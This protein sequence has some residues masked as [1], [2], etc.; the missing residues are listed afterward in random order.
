[1]G[2]PRTEFVLFTVNKLLQN[3]APH[4][5]LRL[6]LGDQLNIRHSWFESVDPG[7]LYVIAEV[8]QETDY[9]T[10]HV[11]KVCAFFL[12]MEAFAAALASRGHAVCYLTLDDTDGESLPD[13]LATIVHQTDASQLEYQRP[14]EY[15]LA[16]QLE[17]MRIESV[18][19]S[20]V[21]TQ[22]FLLPFEEI[23]DYF[24][25]G[26]A[27]R[28]ENF[29][30]KLRVRYNLMMDDDKPLGGR[31]NFDSENR[32]NLKADDIKQVPGTLRF[33]NDA[34]A[35]LERLARHGVHTMGAAAD[36]LLWPVTREQGLEL[37][38]HF[39]RSCLPL[40]GTFQDAMTENGDNAWSL[41][42]SRLSFALNAKLLGP[43]EVI[44]RVID[45]Y[46]SN[47]NIALNQVEGFVRQIMGWR[48][49][50]RGIYWINMP[51][52]AALNELDATR[53]LPDYYW[54]GDTKMNCMR[55]AIE[56]SL[57]L[58][59]A[60]HIQ[61]LMITGNFALLAGVDPDQ[62]DAW[63]LGIYI[64]ALDWVELP[65]TRGMSQFAD[66]GLLA[67]KPYAASG[68]Y[69][70][71]MSDYCRG[72]SYNIKARETDDACP[73]NSLYWRFMTKHRKRLED[74]PRTGMIFRNWDKQPAAQRQS[75]LDRADWCIAHINDL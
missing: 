54:T 63:Y 11:Q 31:W 13:L 39:C 34:S 48:E 2:H 21:D 67:S 29:Y 42:H 24:K 71:K 4:Q 20:C 45:E 60:H 61:R 53:A 66:G 16:S 8:R 52:Y 3:L 28:M 43:L 75:V 44:E 36:A 19:I 58:A 12:A 9:V 56:Q 41:Y 51:G 37:L 68:N 57:E 18:A 49:F 38:E 72:C 1:M 46:T 7:T 30:R 55:A 70:S 73:F 17:A 32:K 10:H 47:G 33:N 23:A 6:V 74:N 50:V 62:V 14:D 15:R 65:N 27:T 22:H 59:Y 69:I 64:D 5:R 26:K 35:V 25:A 40:F